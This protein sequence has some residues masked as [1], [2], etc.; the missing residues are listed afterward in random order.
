MNLIRNMVGREKEEEEKTEGGALKA[1]S[2][3]RD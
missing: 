1:S 2:Y 3:G